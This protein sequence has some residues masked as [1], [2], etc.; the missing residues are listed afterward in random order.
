MKLNDDALDLPCVPENKVRLITRIAR[1]TRRPLHEVFEIIGYADPQII[2][3]SGDGPTIVL[4]TPR[5]E[6]R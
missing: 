5:K 3:A 6:N 2:R 1:N 4:Y